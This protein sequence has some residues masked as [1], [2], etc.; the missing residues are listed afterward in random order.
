MKVKLDDIQI[1]SFITTPE[2]A[3]ER[4]T[5]QAHDASAVTCRYSCVPKYTCPECAMTRAEEI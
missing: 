4:G 5:V 1:E 3:G 2:M